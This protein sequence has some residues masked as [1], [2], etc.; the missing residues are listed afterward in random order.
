MRT[1]RVRMM[2]TRSAVIWTVARPRVIISGP[3]NKAGAQ[4]HRKGEQ[5]KETLYKVHGVQRLFFVVR[6]MAGIVPRLRVRAT[7]TKF[8]QKAAAWAV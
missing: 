8:L 1:V 2:P 7:A 5:Q 4:P 6:E 3:G